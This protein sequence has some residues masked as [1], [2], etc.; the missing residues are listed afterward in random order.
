MMTALN[1]PMTVMLIG[2]VMRGSAFVFRKYDVNSADG[3]PSLE[4]PAF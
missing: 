4:W 1:I 2:I 3:A